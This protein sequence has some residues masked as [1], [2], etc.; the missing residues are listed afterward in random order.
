MPN[1]LDQFVK[2]TES[3]NR[4]L[5]PYDYN[6]VMHYGP[7]AFTKDADL[8]TMSP[9]KTGASLLEVY[10]KYGLSQPDIYSVKKLYKCI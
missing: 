3:E 4:L 6:S 5:V 10:N 8:I 9:K 2:M 1:A 7:T